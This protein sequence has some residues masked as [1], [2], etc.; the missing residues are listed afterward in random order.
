[1]W[2]KRKAIVKEKA[3]EPFTVCDTQQMTLLPCS[4]TFS[5][6]NL[7]P[8]RLLSVCRVSRRRKGATETRAPPSTP[9]TSLGRDLESLASHKDLR[10]DRAL[11]R[12]PIYLSWLFFYSFFFF[13]PSEEYIPSI[14]YSSISHHTS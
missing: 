9:S 8:R 4:H 12:F 7:F 3:S 14:C 11:S 6:C 2:A 13:F 10:E 5:L 1:M